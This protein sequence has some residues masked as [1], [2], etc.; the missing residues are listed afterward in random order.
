MQKEDII[1]EQQ[2][3]EIQYLKED[4]EYLRK[5]NSKLIDSGAKSNES[6]HSTLKLIIILG[7]ISLLLMYGIS[8]YTT[9]KAISER[10]KNINSNI[11]TNYN[12]RSDKD[13]G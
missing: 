10:N 11:N 12:E 4:R 13:G 8:L 1:I 6:F 2:K 7:L 5:V 9:T 3:I